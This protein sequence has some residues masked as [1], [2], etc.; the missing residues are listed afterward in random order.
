MTQRSCTL[1]IADDD[2]Y[3]RDDL[4]DLLKDSGHRLHFS[5]TAAE[6]WNCIER[7]KPDLVLLDLKFP[8]LNDLSL[9]QRIRS[10][11][12]ATQVIVVTSQSGD[13]SQVVAAIKLGAFD[14][15]AKPFVGDEL[16]N[17][18]DKALSLQQLSRSQQYLLEQIEERSGLG[19]LVGKSTAMQQVT[20]QLRRL[21]EADGCVLIRGETGTG[22]E[23][24]ARAL[25]QLSRRRGEPFVVV[26]CAAIPDTLIES[27]LFGHKRGA[28]T[29]AIE[30]SK[31]KFEAAEGG[32]LFLDEIGDMPLAQQTSLLRV[33]E[34][35]TFTPVGE[36]RERECRAR[37]VLATHRDLRESVREGTFREDLYYRIHVASLMMPPL[38]SRTEDIPEL[39]KHYLTRLS[40]EMGRGTI[41]VS[42]DVLQLLQQY[43]WPGNVR[44]LK[45]VLEGAIML[46]ERN[47]EELTVKDLPP[48]LLAARIPLEGG[49][50]TAGDRREKEELL[51]VLRQ[52]QGNQ[53]QA[54]KLLGCHRNTV[55]AK[56]RY[57]GIT[58]L[59]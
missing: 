19:Q 49:A 32:T 46:L 31:G 17:R 54:A 42:A 47:R 15:V 38:R 11:F 20:D 50:L 35:R 44:E 43:D 58:E 6:T 52:C 57:F 28:F 1:V 9:L 37:F 21:A 34:Y 55:R 23:I 39:V 29:G 33:L 59:G 3:I 25:H 13:I 26:N 27:V 40:A 53:S 14:F 18:I 22:K 5:A 10:S 56:I 8:D 51:R 48:E 16:L 12:P 2:K 7:E 30:S 41:R 45:Y 4:A 24:A 36:T